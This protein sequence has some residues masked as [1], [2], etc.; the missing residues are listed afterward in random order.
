MGSLMKKS[1]FVA[2][3]SLT[4]SG[5]AW[6]QLTPSTPEQISVGIGGTAPNGLSD[7]PVTPPNGNLV[8]FRSLASNLVSGDT[9]NW[10]DIF[11]ADTSNTISRISVSSSGQEADGASFEPA[12]SPILPGNVYAVAFASRAT[13]L[14]PEL[15]RGAGTSMQVYLRIPGIKKTILLSKAAAGSLGIEGNDDSTH[16]TVTAV[17]EEKGKRFIVAF[18]SRA[19]NLMGSSPGSPGTANRN[20]KIIF[21]VVNAADGAILSSSEMLPRNG[22]YPDGNVYAPVLSGQGD[23]LAFLTD[24]TNLGWENSARYPQ[25]ATVKKGQPEF[26]LLSRT[27]DGTTGS[28]VSFAPTINFR[29]D[30]VLFKTGAYNIFESSASQPGLALFT[31]ITGGLSLINQTSTGQRGQS[32]R[33]DDYAVGRNGRLV[34]LVDSTDLYVTNDTNGQPDV[35]VK[36][37]TDNSFIRV[38]ISGTGAQADGTSTHV[39]LGGSGYNNDGATVVFASQARSLGKIGDGSIGFVYRVRLTFPPPP[40]SKTTRIETPPDVTPSPKKLDLV[41]QTFTLPDGTTFSL[42]VG[43]AATKRSLQYDIRVSRLSDK[44]GIRRTS[45]SNRVTLRNLTPGSYKVRYRVVGTL[46]SGAT[47]RTSYSPTV[48]VQVPKS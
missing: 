44:R 13:N 4:L 18:A 3:L 25:V 21:V 47:V 28:N 1:I 34:A 24:S 33:L 30:S 14:V 35:F 7:Q 27:E 20:F 11:L 39:A 43:A 16:P 31:A 10:S 32:V 40:L 46:S 23:A 38:N 8:A 6:A 15:G 19:T 2:L 22:V 41:L 26:K 5:S 36:D 42:D 48:T 9:N 45:K 29:G 12:I 17:D 37:L